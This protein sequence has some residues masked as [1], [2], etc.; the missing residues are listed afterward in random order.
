MTDSLHLWLIPVLP[1]VGTAI[2]GLFGRRFARQTVAAVALTFC[3][4]AFAL[5]LYVGAL[6]VA[7]PA[8][9]RGARTLDPVGP[10]HGEFRVLSRSAHVGDAAGGDRSRLPDSHLF[11]RLHVGRRRLLPLL[12]VT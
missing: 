9:H 4:L 11:G 7:G 8:P 2:N 6:L 10:V 5:A 12:R 1:L 3:G